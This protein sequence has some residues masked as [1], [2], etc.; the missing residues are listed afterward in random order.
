MPRLGI[1]WKVQLKCCA[2]GLLG[3]L[4]LETP[5]SL[6]K[7]GVGLVVAVKG[8]LEATH[9]GEQPRTG[10]VG[11]AVAAVQTDCPLEY[12]ESLL[13]VTAPTPVQ[14]NHQKQV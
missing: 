3:V 6:G 2:G 9:F 13:R 8:V 4:N 1:A 11:L 7:V 5:V 10:V 12:Q 14:S